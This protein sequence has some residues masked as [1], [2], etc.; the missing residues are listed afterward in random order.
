M[1][2]R[3]KMRTLILVTIFLLIST[4][5]VA[6][7]NEQG[8]AEQGVFSGNFADAIWTVIAFFLLLIVLGKFAW[9]P[10]LNSLKERQDRIQHEIETAEATRKQ[11]ERLLDD[12]K[13][14]GLK[15][16]EQAT[17]S[18]Q[19]NQQEITEGTRQEVLL[20]RRRAQDDIRHAKEAASERLWNEAADMM[21]SLG[22]KVLGRTVTKEDTDSLVREAIEKIRSSEVDG[23]K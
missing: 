13:Q 6:S 8:G 3:L 12:Y 11:A 17:E 4:A 23:N 5:A 9:R 22:S 2:G 1:S 14:E 16:I 18:A 15:I 20:I 19:Q 21:M 10:L 7:E